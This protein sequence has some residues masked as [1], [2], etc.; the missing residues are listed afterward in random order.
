[1][2]SQSSTQSNCLMIF[3]RLEML[4]SERELTISQVAK[5]TGL[6]RTTLTYMV[7]NNSKGIQLATL[8]QLCQYL[9]VRP[10]DFFEYYPF[11][12]AYQ[13]QRDQDQV[14]VLAE[15]SENG[16]VVQSAQ[17]SG[18]VADDTC[19]LAYSELERQFAKYFDQLSIFSKTLLKNDFKEVA[20]KETGIS[21]ELR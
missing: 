15:L 5:D 1:M 11:D 8:N 17:V 13:F 6:S 9:H 12:L 21:I 14:V 3:N 16:Q 2:I 4:L 19:Q 10:D 7:Q 20:A 18:K